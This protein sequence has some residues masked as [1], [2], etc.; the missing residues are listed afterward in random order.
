M[1]TLKSNY[2]TTHDYRPKQ[3]AVSIGHIAR[4]TSC[5]SGNGKSY[6]ECH[7]PTLPE[8]TGNICPMYV[9]RTTFPLQVLG[10]STSSN[11]KP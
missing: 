5:D 9:S 4:D 1:K 2:K 10:R 3:C 8:H 11:G 6:G 7:K